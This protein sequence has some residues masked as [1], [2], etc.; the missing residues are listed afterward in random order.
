MY[1]LFDENVPYKF[2]QGLDYIEQSNKSPIKAT[3]SHPK[4]IGKEGVPDEEII[5]I[6]GDNKAIIISFDKDFKHIKSYYPLY[7][8]HKVG[9][10]FL[11][12]TKKEANYWGI[13]KLIINNW[14]DLKLRLKDEIPPFVFQVH[15]NGIQKFE[16]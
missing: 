3:I 13:V 12:L 1:F 8:Q 16:F 11:N 5:K 7:R 15:K 4:F 2:V 6:A 9:V 14:E 10:V